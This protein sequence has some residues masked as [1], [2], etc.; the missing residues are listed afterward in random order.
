MLEIRQKTTFLEVINKPIIYKSS[1]ITET[2]DF[3]YF[4]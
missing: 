1:G 4:G 3:S 2:R